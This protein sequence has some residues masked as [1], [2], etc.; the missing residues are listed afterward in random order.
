MLG[1]CLRDHRYWEE[2][3][4]GD[5]LLRPR[6]E[7]GKW[8][9]PSA[10]APPAPEEARGKEF[11]KRG[12]ARGRRRGGRRRAPRV[13]VLRGPGPPHLSPT[14]AP[15]PAAPAPRWLTGSAPDKRRRGRG[16]EQRRPGGAMPAGLLGDRRP[17]ES[18]TRKRREAEVGV[19][20]ALG[21]GGGGQPLRTPQPGLAGRAK[22]SRTH[23]S[24]L[25]R[26]WAP[27]R[28]C[29]RPE[30]LA[31]P[32]PSAQRRRAHAPAPA[33]AHL[34]RSDLRAAPTQRPRARTRCPPLSTSNTLATLT[35]VLLQEVRD[36]KARVS[37]L[38]M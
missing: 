36:A 13:P 35:R 3:R 32:P 18:G 17:W 34:M 24:L 27:A 28:G 30:A 15:L 14:R 16:S 10:P 19:G 6:Q 26:P 4:F 38:L 23:P 29:A 20:R 37:Y 5:G 25:W 21:A 22:S 8:R 11:P 7:P 1:S 33:H 12:P 9:T 2:W 31:A